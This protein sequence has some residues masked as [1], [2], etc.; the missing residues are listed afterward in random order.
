[1]FSIED[2]IESAFYSK[3]RQSEEIL[4]NYNISVVTEAYSMRKEIKIKSQTYFVFTAGVITQSE[5]V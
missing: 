2:L 4:S 5:F 1:M 3:T